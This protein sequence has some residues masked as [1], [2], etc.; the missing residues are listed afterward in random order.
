MELEDMLYDD[1]LDVQ[2]IIQNGFPRRWNDR[3]DYFETMDDYGFFRRFRLTKP[4]V[5]ALLEEI[6]HAL[7]HNNQM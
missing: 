1:D 5:A 6:E 3:T 7:V 4:T 2:D